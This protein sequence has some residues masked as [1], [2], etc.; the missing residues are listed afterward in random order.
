MEAQKQSWSFYVKF[1]V[2]CIA[3]A[4]VS[5]YFSIMTDIVYNGFKT[6]YPLY[7]YWT[8]LYTPVVFVIIVYL[9]KRYFPDAGG[10]GL[11]QGYAVDVFSHQQLHNVYSVRTM[12][13][14]M[15]LTVLTIASGAALGRE[16][17]TVQICASIL[18]SMRHV[19]ISYQKLLIRIGSGIG[20]ATAFNTPL[21]GLMFAFEEYLKISCFKINVL[22]VL[23]VTVAGGV[24]VMIYG[25]YSY[26]GGVPVSTLY[27]DTKTLILS[28]VAS[29]ICGLT[30]ALFTYCMVYVSVNKGQ[31]FY[32]W[33]KKHYLLMAFVFGFILAVMG[34]FNGTF[35]FGNGSVEMKKM[36]TEGADLPWFYSLAKSISALLAVAAGVPGGYFSTSIS[37][38]AG[39][40]GSLHHYWPVLPI[41]QFYLLGMAGFVA[42][43]SCAPL[44]AIVMTLGVV[45]NSEHLMLPI[46][47]TAV[48]SSYIASRF[49]DSVYH[50]QVLIYI[51]KDKYEKT[52]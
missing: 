6:L 39:L 17:P 31:W 11:P 36:I 41:E 43:I 15:I 12:I 40:M 45:T 49:G 30:G 9:M 48:C 27:C 14:K 26:L 22:L 24:G 21:G 32:A 2:L 28:L 44:T 20:I 37:I 38:G 7:P 18:G 47:M 10:S 50:Q 35:A 23:G 34:F 19:S 33:I 52:R 3:A 29:L 5:G 51:D 13:G 4:I 25:N 46:M 1:V 42:A 16:G 8:L